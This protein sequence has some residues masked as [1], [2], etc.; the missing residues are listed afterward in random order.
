MI[1]GSGV[2]MGNDICE[3]VEH[4]IWLRYRNGPETYRAPFLVAVSI[5]LGT[6]HHLVEDYALRNFRG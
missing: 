2:R 1:V 5:V 4:F 6:E 3:I